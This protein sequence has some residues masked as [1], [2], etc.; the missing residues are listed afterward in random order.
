MA[1]EDNKT[2]AC[3]NAATGRACQT[4]KLLKGPVGM[5]VAANTV[6]LAPYLLSDRWFTWLLYICLSVLALGFVAKK[7]NMHKE[8]PKD[9]IKAEFLTSAAECIASNGNKFI[10]FSWSVV[11]WEDAPLSLKSVVGLCGLIVLSWIFS[12]FMLV[13]LAVN[14]FLGYPLLMENFGTEIHAALEQAHVVVKPHLEK[15]QVEVE[16]V[17]KQIPGAD[18]YLNTEEKKE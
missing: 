16:K 15:A 3:D 17:V 1:S 9:V 2:G 8:L 18:K 4:V 7:L 6:L 14:A 12:P 11:C 13:W 5:I 10:N